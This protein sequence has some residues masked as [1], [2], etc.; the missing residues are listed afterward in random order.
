MVARAQ[1]STKSA[2]P[3]TTILKIWHPKIKTWYRISTDKISRRTK[4]LITIWRLPNSK[5]VPNLMK[6]NSTS[7]KRGS[8]RYQTWMSTG[9]SLCSDIGRHREVLMITST[10][11]EDPRPRWIWEGIINISILKPDPNRKRNTFLGGV[12][13]QAEIRNGQKSVP[14]TSDFDIME[15]PKTE[16]STLY[17]SPRPCLRHNTHNSTALIERETGP[18]PLFIIRGPHFPS[19]RATSVGRPW[20]QIWVGTRSSPNYEAKLKGGSNKGW[21]RRG[22]G[23]SPQDRSQVDSSRK[24]HSQIWPDHLKISTLWHKDT[25]PKPNNAFLVIDHTKKMS[26]LR[27]PSRSSLTTQIINTL[28][29]RM[30]SRIRSWEIKG[31]SFCK[32]CTTDVSNLSI[33][34]PGRHPLWHSMAQIDI[35]KMPILIREFSTSWI[36]IEGIVIPGRWIWAPRWSSKWRFSNN[37]WPWIIR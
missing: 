23:M 31:S 22:S 36:I 12:S 17:S 5:T 10:S 13:P 35:S 30:W 37:R 34:D 21:P 24:R 33:F 18:S 9:W 28:L 19:H 16:T 15:N 11:I 7:T 6:R 20:R 25:E 3:K 1:N 4:N 26:I 14:K 8:L 2:P 32:I 29:I 27:M